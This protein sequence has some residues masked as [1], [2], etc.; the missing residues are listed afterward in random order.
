MMKKI[1][2][3]SVLLVFIV[4]AI[5]SLFLFYLQSSIN[6]IL[7]DQQITVQDIKSPVFRDFLKKIGG[8]KWRLIISRAHPSRPSYAVFLCGTTDASFNIKDFNSILLKNKS[9]NTYNIE[10]LLALGMVKPDV[11]FEEL[12]YTETMELIYIYSFRNEHDNI[13]IAYPSYTKNEIFKALDH[14]DVSSLK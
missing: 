10:K 9:Y 7:I 6:E 12:L 5:V 14:V 8:T 1:L 13:I 4:F 11:Q 2:L 3:I